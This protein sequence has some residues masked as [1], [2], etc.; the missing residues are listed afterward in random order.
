MIGYGLMRS[1][2]MWLLQ[3][4]L[5]SKGAFGRTPVKKSKQTTGFAVPTQVLKPP[6]K[7]IMVFRQLKALKLFK[8]L[9]FHS[10][11]RKEAAKDGNYNYQSK[12]SYC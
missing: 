3:G 5:V 8:P 4:M 9:N 12:S 1:V 2:W 7:N 11:L 10:R 6:P